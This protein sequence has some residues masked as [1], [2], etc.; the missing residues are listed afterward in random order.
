ME[1]K[2]S[3]SFI[4]YVAVFIITLFV[5]VI[6]SYLSDFFT[7]KKIQS[8][9]TIQDNIFL[10][11]LSS[12][13]QFSLLQ[14]IPCNTDSG[15]I[16]SPEMNNLAQKVASS[17]RS[18]SISEDE[19]TSLKKYYSIL[20]IKDY[21]LMKRIS[22]RCSTKNEFMLYFY[23][24]DTCDECMKQEYVLDAL[25]VKYPQ[26][27]VYLFD[28]KLDLSALR[29]M[30]SIY[31]PEKDSTSWLVVNDKVYTGF[32]SVEDIEKIIPTLKASVKD[33][34]K[35]SSSGESATSSSKPTSKTR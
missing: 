15:S 21:L 3:S 19:I 2:D 6:A 7:N 20:E 14:E 27:R 11:L 9:K 17:E 22:Q 5:F 18:S 33:E 4:K 26:L 1:K 30:I 31:K 28:T 34:S 35:S 16:V 23:E 24:S 13:T 25:R 29:S 32:K 10:D 8:I 12:E